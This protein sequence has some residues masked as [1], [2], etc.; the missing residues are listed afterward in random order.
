MR[1]RAGKNVHPLS[2]FNPTPIANHWL[3]HEHRFA[4]KKTS[5]TNKSKVLAK[6]KEEQDASYDPTIFL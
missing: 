5:T 2:R 6:L 1:S 4:E 3:E